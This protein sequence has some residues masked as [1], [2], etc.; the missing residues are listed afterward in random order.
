MTRVPCE[1]CGRGLRDPASAARRIGPVCARKL[2]P[3]PPPTVRPAQPLA[4]VDGQ[5]LEDAGQLTIT[6]EQHAPH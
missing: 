3:T 6:E 2:R 1:V 4:V 5:A